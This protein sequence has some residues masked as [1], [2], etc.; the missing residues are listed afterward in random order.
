MGEDGTTVLEEAMSE[1][2]LIDGKM[3]AYRAHFS[4][5]ALKNADGEPTGL[6][7]GFFYEL[8]SINK[9]MPEA[10]MIICWDGKGKTWRHTTYPKYKAQRPYNPEWKRMNAQIVELLPILKKLGFHVYEVDGVEAD[11]IIGILA[12]QL[13]GHDIRIYSGDRDMYQLVK[14]G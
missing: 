4:H 5:M 9:K 14:G 2:I 10:R 11:D 1:V 13:N 3:V 6:L 7:H 8:L 12:T